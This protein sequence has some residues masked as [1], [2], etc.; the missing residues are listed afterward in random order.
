[1]FDEDP[2]EDNQAVYE[3]I[4]PILHSHLHRVRVLV[5]LL[6]EHLEVLPALFPVEQHFN[7]CSLETFYSECYRL[8]PPQIPPLATLQAPKIK[9]LTVLG[10]LLG[11][12]SP[13]FENL[14]TMTV[15]FD[16]PTGDKELKAISQCCQLQ[17]LRLY[18]CAPLPN[19][20]SFDFNFHHLRSLSLLLT[21]EQ[22]CLAI[23]RHVHTPKLEQFHIIGGFPG[24][25]SRAHFIWICPFLRQNA[26]L[27]M[28][29]LELLK[30]HVN[31]TD[32]FTRLGHLTAL[33]IIDCNSTNTFVD[34]FLVEVNGRLILP[35]LRLFDFRSSLDFGDDFPT[36]LVNVARTRLTDDEGTCATVILSGDIKP[37]HHDWVELRELTEKYP[38]HC[39]VF[40]HHESS[41]EEEE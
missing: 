40:H 7:L 21:T 9:E 36:N 35:N 30:L 31:M 29:E 25:G 26:Q 15:H 6:P 17:D 33:R 5:L 23:S 11:S 22:S 24:S 20:L 13:P 1:M 12:F 2:D 16:Y 34:T 32:C 8:P 28:L 37:W 38:H 18:L 27:K 19:S 4:L 14:S 10:Q 3:E 39:F 41:D